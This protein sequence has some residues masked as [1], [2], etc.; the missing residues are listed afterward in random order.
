MDQRRKLHQLEREGV[1]EREADDPSEEFRRLMQGNR[2]I[3]GA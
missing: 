3:P 1:I 2:A